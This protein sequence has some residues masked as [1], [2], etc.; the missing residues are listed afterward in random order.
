MKRNIVSIMGWTL[1]SWVLL[2]AACTK[3][4]YYYKDYIIERNYVGKPDSIWIHPGDQ[5]VQIGMLTPK[6]A[7]A[8][9][10]IIR[11]DTKDSL[12]V[13][14]DR[15]VPEQTV[16]IDKLEERDYVFNAYTSDQ[17][18]K[19]SLP[20][21]LSCP[22]YG[23]AFRGTIQNRVLSHSVVFPDSVALV[24]NPMVS[25][26]LYGVE[27]RY[28][29]K[30]GVEQ[31]TSMSS[32]SLV[33][34]VK[35]VDLTVPVSVRTMFRPHVNAFDYFYTA[36]QTVDIATTGR[37]SLILVSDAYQNAE[38]IDFKFARV[39]LEADV[40]KP[41]GPDID[42]AY[43]LGGSSR[44]NLFTMAGEGFKAFA[45]NWQAAIN[46]WRI[47]NAGSLKL[48]RTA[49]ALATYN[50]L[51][52][53]NRTQMVAAYENSTAN[54]LDRISS[55]RVNDV[56]YLHSKDRDIYVAMKV[57][58]VPPAVSGAYGTFSFDF[59]VSRL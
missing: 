6:D 50:G 31:T 17:K 57:T 44:S 3:M 38:Y 41:L 53:M 34:I 45:D 9:E 13:P 59:K 7:E 42:M 20:M 55:L 14:I 54:P 24:W 2:F 52:E 30:A 58:G 56:I 40:P 35:D 25:N 1:C 49:G 46:F 48:D 28:T 43:T 26:T 4:D 11:W 21:E 33:N 22:V 15:E 27:I 36:P 5:R 18:G 10:W 39:F 8:K 23:P 37:H 29:D 16:I 19:R 47:R 32:G 12:V 51:D